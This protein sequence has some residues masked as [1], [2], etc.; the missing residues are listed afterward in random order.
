VGAKF[1]YSFVLIGNMNHPLQS[2]HRLYLLHFKLNKGLKEMY[3]SLSLR[4]FALHLVGIFV[5]I[6]LYTLGFEILEIVMFFGLYHLFHALLVIFVAGKLAKRFGV[7]HLMLFSMPFLFLYLALVALLQYYLWIPL[8]LLAFLAG[9]SSSL[10]WV[11]FHSEFAKS[12]DKKHRG[13][14]SSIMNVLSSI[15]AALGPAIG[16]VII[17]MI[18]YLA[19]YGLVLFVLL[20]SIIPLFMSKDFSGK[21]KYLISK[22]YS[23]RSFRKDILPHFVFGITGAL[24]LAL[25]PLIIYL[26]DIFGNESGLGLVFTLTFVAGIF[27][28][29]YV[30]RLSDRVKNYLM[31]FKISNLL[32]AII[33]V[34]RWFV[35]S[36]GLLFGIEIV[37]GLNRPFYS[38][39]LEKHSY[40]RAVRT[41]NVVEYIVFKESVLHFSAAFIMFV[42]WLFGDLFIAPFLASITHLLVLFI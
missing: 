20:L 42:V 41:K 34:V 5:P 8:V 6:Y 25:W 3:A 32:F 19:L 31:I 12:T 10:Y 40:N 38:V 27:L 1:L 30:G 26:K 2:H 35:Q 21:K 17:V 18:G 15:V 22:V 16:G 39:P 29:F 9:V 36:V 11:G 24:F 7:K 23:H 13:E 33:W 28:A 37:A 4:T 14:E